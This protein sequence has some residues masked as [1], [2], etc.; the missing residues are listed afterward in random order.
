MPS[1]C[2]AHV[3]VRLALLTALPFFASGRLAR[4][5]APAPTL[6]YYSFGG[7]ANNGTSPSGGV[8]VGPGGALYGTA[9]AGGS[10]TNCI[11]GG[12]G[13]VYSAIPPASSGG[14]WVETVLYTF[15]GGSDGANPQGPLVTGGNGMLYGTTQQGGTGSCFTDGGC[16][17]VFS[18]APPTVPGGSW[19]ETV[20]YRFTGVGD[21]SSPESGVVLGKDGA[22][23]GTAANGGSTAC[24]LTGQ[25][26]G[27]GTVFSLR[28]PASPGAAWTLRVLYE[29]PG[30]PGGQ[31]PDG[32]VFGPDQVLYG[33]TGAGGTGT[34]PCNVA[35]CGTVFSLTPPASPGAPWAHAVIYDF[36][37]ANDGSHPGGVVIGQPSEGSI[38]LYGTTARG[39]SQPPC[40]SAGM[41]CGTVFA[42]AS[43]A[44]L[45]G[46]WTETV[47]YTFPSFF[48]TSAVSIEGGLLFV[49][50]YTTVYVMIPPA[51]PTGTWSAKVLWSFTSSSG[52]GSPFSAL[53]LAHGV[54]YGASSEGGD[55]NGG[56]VFALTP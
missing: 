46:P 30:G 55:L 28:P 7:V 23:Y 38:V 26:P 18:L 42:L 48:G 20:L 34:G 1:I 32:L 49:L 25:L 37:G 56:T 3:A 17:T 36:Q 27:C 39:G 43:P 31:Y 12:C 41:D 22:L 50:T 9:Y 35:G 24:D 2:R 15:Q 14:T 6:T 52:P 45:G 54:L 4:A 51:M 16:G 13:T 29:F 21:G 11:D 40:R 8:L 10:W 44:S 5:Q 33:T 19:T 47:L 53:T